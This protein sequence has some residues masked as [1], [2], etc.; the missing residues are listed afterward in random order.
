MSR[1]RRTRKQAWSLGHKQLVNHEILMKNEDGA[2]P[3]KISTLMKFRT[4][5]EK[6]IIIYKTLSWWSQKQIRTM[7]RKNEDLSLL[8]LLCLAAV[9]PL[10]VEHSTILWFRL[11][12][13]I[14]QLIKGK[15]TK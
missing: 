1:S 2:R 8:H 14:A 15:G 7:Y 9:A 4:T 12:N 10:H 6:T 13:I 5:L 3:Q 11:N